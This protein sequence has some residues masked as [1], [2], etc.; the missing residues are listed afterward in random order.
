[1][2]KLFLIVL[3]AMMVLPVVA[4]ETRKQS[5]KEL[6]RQ[7][8]NAIIKQEEEGVIKYKKHTSFGVKTYQ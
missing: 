8:I 7:R 2:K 3:T 4:Q 5:K 6:R 1:M